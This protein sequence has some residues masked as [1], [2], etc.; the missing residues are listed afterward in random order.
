MWDETTKKDIVCA[1]RHLLLCSIG[2]T[3][4][5]TTHLLISKLFH[6]SIVADKWIF[7]FNAI[8]IG[9]KAFLKN[10]DMNF[11]WNICNLSF[12]MRLKISESSWRLKAISKRFWTY[13][14]FL[15]LICIQYGDLSA[16]VCNKLPNRSLKSRNNVFEI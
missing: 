9:V 13:F 6:A 2:D 3:K 12:Y 15:T 5:T 14:P 7:D 16:R 4:D 1:H 11:D 8:N 10:F